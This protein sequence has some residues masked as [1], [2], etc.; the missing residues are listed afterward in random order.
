MLIQ[1]E[2]EE[3]KLDLDEIDYTE[4][5]YIKRHT[6]LTLLELELGLE[7]IDPDALGAL[8]WLMMKQSGT[9]V[10][11]QKVNFK[12]LKFTAALIEAKKREAEENPTKEPDE[13]PPTNQ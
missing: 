5:R 12:A 3:Y 2:D 9:A 4:A 6:G 7:K 13:A 8:Y 1:F 11:L 10:D